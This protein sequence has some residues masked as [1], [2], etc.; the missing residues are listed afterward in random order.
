GHVGA[1]DRQSDVAA[2]RLPLRRPV[3]ELC[4][5]PRLPPVTERDEAGALGDGLEDSRLVLYFPLLDPRVALHPPE[6]LVT[7]RAERR[8]SD[9][10]HRDDPVAHQAYI[11]RSR[12]IPATRS[13]AIMYDAMR[14]LTLCRSAH[15]I[16][17]LYTHTM[18][19]S[20]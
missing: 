11:P 3:R 6:V 13:T 15:V 2:V 17:S 18:R 7:G 5:C 8:I 9:A 14:G 19:L 10:A 20:R 16:T 12:C 1:A 4:G